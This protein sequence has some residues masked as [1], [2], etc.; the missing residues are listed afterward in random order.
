MDAFAQKDSRKLNNY[1]NPPFALLSRVLDVIRNQKAYVKVIAPHSPGQT[2]YQKLLAV[3]INTPIK[4][5]ISNRA[6]F[7]VGPNVEPLKNTAW[8]IYAWRVYGGL[9]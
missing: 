4:L 9:D 1:V 7:A 5:P 6:V 2:L 8:E 3:M